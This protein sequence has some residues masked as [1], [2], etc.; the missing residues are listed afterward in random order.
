LENSKRIAGII[1]FNG[2]VRPDSFSPESTCPN[3]EFGLYRSNPIQHNWNPNVGQKK[4]FSPQ[5]G[6]H[7]T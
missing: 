7:S 3:C 6:S 4:E 1:V 5:K 2:T